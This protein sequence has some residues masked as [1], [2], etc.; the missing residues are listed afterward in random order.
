MHRLFERIAVRVDPVGMATQYERA[1]KGIPLLAAASTRWIQHGRLPAYGVLLLGF[2]A[3]LTAWLLVLF[4]P[5]FDWPGWEP[6]SAGFVGACLLIVAGSVLSLFQ[7][8]RLV[9]L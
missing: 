9:L 4:W 5:S 1:L 3:L 7:A 2:V 8:D 6:V